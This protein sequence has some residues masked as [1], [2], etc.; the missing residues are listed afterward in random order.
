M[1]CGNPHETPCHEVLDH[2]YEY[3]DH[4]IDDPVWLA[5]IKQ[6][7]YEC[8]PCLKMYGLDKAVKAIVHRSCGH[9]DVPSDLRD[10]VLA[11]IRQA[12]VQPD[13]PDVI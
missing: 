6:H 13:A 2:V 3:L 5:K 8:S 11:R 4:E 12:R 1:S 10:K 9:D 7:L